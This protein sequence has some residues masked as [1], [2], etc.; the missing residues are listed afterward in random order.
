MSFTTEPT[1]GY[2]HDQTAASVTWTIVH[3][4]NTTAPVVDCWVA[5]EKVMPATVTAT[6]AATV[7]I[8]FSTAE[9]GVAYVA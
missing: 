3:N 7:T 1:Y 5:G 2:R 9:S 4:L 6:D 8:T